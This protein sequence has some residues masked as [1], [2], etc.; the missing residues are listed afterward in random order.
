MKREL[1]AYDRK[2]IGR[3]RTVGKFATYGAL[4]MGGA[5]I[6]GELV[7]PSVAR[8]VGAAGGEGFASGVARMQDVL[9][10]VSAST[11]GRRFI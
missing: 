3:A 5:L 7:G 1:S 11:R 10:S 8:S 9:A 6:I 2:W 4:F